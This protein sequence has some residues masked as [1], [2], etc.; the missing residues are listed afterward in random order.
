MTKNMMEIANYTENKW[1]KPSLYNKEIVGAID[2]KP[3]AQWGD[4]KL[5][6]LG[7]ISHAKD[8]GHTELAKTSFHDRAKILKA[9]AT[10]LNENKNK[11]YEISHLT[12]A[13]Q[14]DNFIDVDGGIGTLFVYASKGRREMPDD[15]VYLHGEMEVLSRNGNF[16]G[17]H[18][19]TPKLGVAL[20]INAF[21]FPVWGMLEKFAQSFLAGVPSIIKPATVTSYLTQVCVEMMIESEMLPKGSLQLVGGRINGLFAMLDAQD[22]VS[23]TGSQHTAQIIAKE[24]K[25][26]VNFNAEQD[27]LNGAI[28]GEDANENSKELD[29][30]IDE[31]VNEMTTKAGQKCTAMRRLIVPKKMMECVNEKI[32]E[33]LNNIKMGDPRN[34]DTDIGALVSQEQKINVLKNA[35]VIAQECK[36]V[37]NKKIGDT[38]NGSFL[39][40]HLYQCDNPVDAKFVHSVEAFG[41]VATVMGYDNIS[42]AI[43]LANKGGGS[44]VVS[45]FSDD[46]KFAR[47]VTLGIAPW[48]GRV[49]I[50]NEKSKKEATG[51]GSPLP[52]M[53]HGGPGRAGNGEELGGIRG[54]LHYM[55]QTAIQGNPDVVGEICGEW[56]IGGAKKEMGV[57]PFQQT[58]NELKL[59]TTFNSELRKITKKDIDTFSN[60]TGDTFYAHTDNDAA[61]KNPFFPG[62]VA[63]G[64]LILSFAAGLF[65]EPNAGPVLANTGLLNLAFLKPVEPDDSIKVSLTVKRKTKRNDEYGEVRWYVEVSNQNDE[66][67]AQYQLLTMNAYEN[68]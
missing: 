20:H 58:F 62:I 31:V 64:Y 40:P 65:V 60:F 4:I 39:Q 47:E 50:N 24:L 57:H 26:E 3:V 21:N 9:I 16:V 2:D 55:Q 13:T 35:E 30:F 18:I 23:F 67:V 36:C 41:P 49:Y 59:G 43:E 53:I 19:Y 14:K 33:K 46:N 45:I 12:G 17:Q 29:I 11:L 28:L 1:V 61:M 37:W 42:Q 38:E 34:E 54:V 27:S 22:S 7:I 48:H 25:D 66:A 15:V 63:H 5:N 56:M 51:H 32:S 68:E 44:L 10:H 6:A 52:H 8:T